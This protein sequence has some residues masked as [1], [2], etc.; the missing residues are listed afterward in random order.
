MASGSAID[1][2]YK[3]CWAAKLPSYQETVSPAPPQQRW[4]RPVDGEY[5]PN[6]V[7]VSQLQKRSRNN[8][9]M[10]TTLVTIN[11]WEMRVLPG[12]LTER[13]GA[14]AGAVD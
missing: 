12:M 3:E 8:I 2:Q 13:Q 14:S 7:P 4:D 11:F 10:S 6:D 9:A 1:E 5:D